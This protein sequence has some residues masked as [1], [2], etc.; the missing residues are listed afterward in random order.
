MVDVNDL[1]TRV[2]C[3]LLFADLS[4]QQ[5]IARGPTWHLFRRPGKTDRKPSFGVR[6]SGAKD[7]TD[8]QW[9]DAFQLIGLLE[10]IHS[11][12]AQAERLVELLSGQPTVVRPAAALSQPSPVST[13]AWQ[14]AA[15]L[16]VRRCQAWLQHTPAVLDWLHTARGIDDAT[17][18]VLGLGYNPDWRKTECSVQDEQGVVRRV[19]LAPGLLI[20]W[21]LDGQ[22]QA[23]KVRRVV[24]SLASA[25]G[26]PD[27]QQ[28]VWQQGRW[29]PLLDQHG[30]GLPAPKYVQLAGGSRAGLYGGERLSAGCTAVLVEGELD[31]A[32]LLSSGDQR[33]VPVTLGSAS[34]RLSQLAAD[35]R[36]RLMACAQV[37]VATDSDEV[38]ERAAQAL[39]AELGA[40]GWRQTLHGAK[41]VSEFAVEQAGDVR[42]WLSECVLHSAQVAL[43]DGWRSLLLGSRHPQAVLLVA[44]LALVW[45]SGWPLPESCS[46]TLSALLAF[47]KQRGFEL[48]EQVLRRAI[49]QDLADVDGFL[50]ECAASV[51]LCEQ[52]TPFVGNESGRPPRRYT[53]RRTRAEWLERQRLQAE[54]QVRER[55]SEGALLL[56][57]AQDVLELD[58]SASDP[59]GLARRIAERPAVQKALERDAQRRERL[60]RQA[61]LSVQLR[62]SDQQVSVWPLSACLTLHA[63]RAAALHTLVARAP[64]ELSRARL[65]DWIGVHVSRLVPFVSEAQ[66]VIERQ[67]LQVLSIEQPAGLQHDL[68]GQP[69]AMRLSYADGRIERQTFHRGLALQ[70]LAQGASLEVLVQPPN[71]VRLARSGERCTLPERVERAGGAAAVHRSAA[72]RRVARLA[73]QALGCLI[74]NGAVWQLRAGWQALRSGRQLLA[75]LL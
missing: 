31:V 58:P 6:A 10:G 54:Q 65:A 4:G 73:E 12:P 13:A 57:D 69:V 28:Q 64:G 70:A 17:I 75:L 16:E 5:P 41:D 9:Y 40:L 15:A 68:G 45:P 55:R 18:E 21:W 32:V 23:I 59:H 33:V 48:A 3:R 29:Q 53:F 47:F 50:T 52:L 74:A 63:A 34:G 22:V 38:G 19:W 20:P 72:W 2:D 46:F 37:V 11:F 56:P 71:Y 30:Q 49:K 35:M 36:A 42:A 44:A 24:G 27:A 67:A 39:L 51:V 60:A 7:F 61:L 66:L 14:R 43:S 62:L 25:L 1:R 26:V 8:G